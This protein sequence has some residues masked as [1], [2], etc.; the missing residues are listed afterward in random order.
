MASIC[1]TDD[2]LGFGHVLVVGDLRISP[3][4]A[5]YTS[6]CFNTKNVDWVRFRGVSD[7]GF[8]SLP[9]AP[10]G[11]S[12]TVMLY[13][14]FL[15]LITESL[16]AILPHCLVRRGPRRSGGT[17]NAMRLLLEG[18]MPS[19]N[20]SLVRKKKREPVAGGL[21]RRSR[22]FSEEKSTSHLSPAANPSIPR[23]VWPGFRGRSGL[24]LLVSLILG[25]AIERIRTHRP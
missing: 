24:S 15:R 14:E 16:S 8:S 25:R 11:C 10:G 2:T 9:L 20:T 19:R 1:V 4:Y 7:D 5:R 3:R 18:V 12:N 13:L 21:M 17:Q 6:N 23:W 22:D